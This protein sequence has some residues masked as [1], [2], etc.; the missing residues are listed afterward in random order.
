MSY[1]IFNNGPE[2]ATFYQ[3]PRKCSIGK[4]IFGVVITLVVLGVALGV[5]LGIGLHHPQPATA[6]AS[7]PTENISYTD[8]GTYWSPTAG[9]TW[10]IVLLYPLNDTSTN[11]SVYDID[12]FINNASTISLLHQ[13]NRRTICYF[14]AGSYEDFRPD[15]SNFTKSDYGN[16]LTGWQGEWWVDTRSQNVRN[17]MLSRLDHAASLGCDG[18]DP[19]NIDA[20][21]NDNG[22]GLTQDD[23]VDYLT[24]LAEAAHARN[25]SIGLKNGGDIIGRV[26]NMM[27]WE[28]NEQCVQ[29][30]ECD[31]YR[32][33]IAQNKPVFHIEYPSSAPN[34][35]STERA[36]ICANQGA[37]GFSTIL[38]DMDLDDWVEAC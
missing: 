23:A 3:L 11:A 2:K 31:S 4:I 33:F 37:V 5:G 13:Q 36:I 8:N 26:L 21:A 9:T 29:Y 15:S 16:P 22:L 24:F 6:A 12:L 10:Q 30:S 38:K 7:A 19:D 32:P 14:S 17:I 28:V 34:V 35:G 27:Q 20:Y 25:M 18:V 1:N